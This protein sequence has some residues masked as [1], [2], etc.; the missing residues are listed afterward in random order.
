[1]RF[2]TGFHKMGTRHEKNNSEGL[3]RSVRRNQ[4]RARV[5]RARENTIRSK[6]GG[7]AGREMADERE[8]SPVARLMGALQAEKIRFQIIGMSAAIVQGVPGSTNDIDIWVDLSSRQYMRAIKAAL[9]G[10]AKFVRN[11]VVAL[12]DETLVNFVYEVTGLGSFRTEFKKSKP[13]VFHGLKVQVLPLESIRKSKLA[14]N[15][16]KDLIHIYQ[17][18]KLLNCKKER[19][20]KP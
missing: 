18:N 19:E 11:T 4:K 16:P 17:I 6:P 12:S 13:Y 10:G 9:S 8:L 3:A 14:I 15:R 5:G 20:R 1:M 7:D 2:S